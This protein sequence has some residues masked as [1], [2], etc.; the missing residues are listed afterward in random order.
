MNEEKVEDP[1]DD[2]PE[3]SYEKR[4]KDSQS[5]ITKLEQ[6]NAS[7]RDQS[8]KDKELFDTVSQ[9]VDWDKANG[10]QPVEDDGYV[11]KKTLNKQIKD[12]QDQMAR[13]RTTQDFRIKYPDMVKYEDL[14]GIFLGKTDTRRPLNERIDS[15]VDSAKKLIESE[16]T[17]GREDFERE[18]KEKD[19]KEAEASGLSDGK[20]PK[21][22]EKEPDGETYEEY[23]AFRKNQANKQW[24]PDASLQK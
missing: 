8:A 10:V 1:K 17:K 11:D 4:Y 21:G 6:E 20:G 7:M 22:E 24:A 12:L 23:I 18:K 15:A 2:K 13:D 9:Y 14:V 3:D 19:A 5:H 16:R